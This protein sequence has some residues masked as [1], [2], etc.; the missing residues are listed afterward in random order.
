MNAQAEEVLNETSA[1]AETVPTEGK[2]RAKAETVRVTMTDGRQVD[3]TGKRKMLK[4]SEFDG[5]NWKGT[6]FDFKDGK[7]LFYSAPAADLQTAEGELMLHKLAAHGSE[8]KIG[9]ETAGK[10]DNLSDMYDAVEDCIDRLNKGEW[11]TEGTG[12][13]AFGMGILLRALAEFTGK[14]QDQLRPWLKS[15]TTDERKALKATP[16][17][18]PIIQRMEDEEAA[19]TAHVDTDALLAGIA[20]A[21]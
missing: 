11:Y 6:R 9:D 8:Q 15:R 21:T 1:A 10:T 16:K 18:K 5:A 20:A 3:F 13:G 2:K 12:A 19:K 7:T 4:S 17:L 14:T